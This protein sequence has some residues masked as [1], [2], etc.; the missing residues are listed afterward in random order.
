M[1]DYDVVIVGGRVA[2]ASLAIRLARAGVR[3]LV[4][5]RATMPSLPATSCPIIY[6]PAMA[7]LDELGISENAYAASTPPIRSWVIEAEGYWKAHPPVPMAY[8]R[9]YSYAVDRARLDG[10]LWEAASSL[11][12]CHVK[13]QASVTQIEASADAVAV[14]T[15]DGARYTARRVVGCDGRFSR[16]A[17]TFH[18]PEF[19]HADEEPTSIYYAYWEGVQP[20]DNGEAV[21]HMISHGGDYG[22]LVAESSDGRTLVTIEG[23]SDVLTPE[24]GQSLEAFYRAFLQRSDSMSN[25]LQGATL[26]PSVKGMKRVGNLYRQAS[27]EVWA[28]AGDA[29]HQKDPLDGQG[30]YDA[31]F[32]SKALA[33][34]IIAWHTQHLTWQQAMT[35][36]QHALWTETAPMY[37]STLARVNRELYTRRPSWFMHTLAHWLYTDPTYQQH[38]GRLFVRDIA[39]NQWWSLGVVMPSVMRGALKQSVSWLGNLADSVNGSRSIQ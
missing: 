20:Y 13:M 6:S 26:L 4:L 15:H 1:T 28:L 30:I 21:A 38:W 18:A 7:L 29:V 11:P 17:Q 5:E 2:G 32:T 31:L 12:F 16:V 14:H 34:G 23:R 10:C 19:H 3:T 8:G 35:R 22:L 25:R 24:K 36:Y 33:E 27:G 39:P 37:R 9:D